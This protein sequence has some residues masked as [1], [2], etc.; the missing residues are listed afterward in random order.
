M[1]SLAKWFSVSLTKWLWV[2]VPLQVSRSRA[3]S[4]IVPVFSKEF[5]DIQATLE[6]E[7]TLKCVRDMIRTYT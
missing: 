4:D 3:T 6:C 7:C 2:R 1:A 5:L